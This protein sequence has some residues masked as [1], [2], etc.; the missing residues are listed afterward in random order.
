ME[1]GIGHPY[2]ALIFQHLALILMSVDSQY[3]SAISNAALLLKGWEE[4]V[5]PL[6]LSNLEE[7]SAQYFTSWPLTIR[8][9][10]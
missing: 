8:L 2:S 10:Y 4:V 3:Q 7:R 9:W 6:L 5:E 1:R